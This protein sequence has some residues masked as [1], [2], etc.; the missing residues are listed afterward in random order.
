[1]CIRDRY[2]IN[3]K[4]ILGIFISHGHFDHYGSL[5][6]GNLDIPIYMTSITKDIIEESNSEFQGRLNNVKIIRCNEEIS[7]GS[8]KI[9]AVEN[10]HILGSCAFDIEVVG[11]RIIYLGDFCLSRCV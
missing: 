2:N 9:K 10:G 1:M 4:D 6:V 11:K 7:L 8:F 5:L 3:Y